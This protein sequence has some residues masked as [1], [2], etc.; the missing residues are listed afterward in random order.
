[1]AKP[2]T[3]LTSSGILSRSFLDEPIHL[4]GFLGM[5]SVFNYV[6]LVIIIQDWLIFF[7]ANWSY[8]PGVAP[9]SNLGINGKSVDPASMPC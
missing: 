5:W 6:Y 9:N 3:S 7:L 4:S 2:K 8:P 1:M